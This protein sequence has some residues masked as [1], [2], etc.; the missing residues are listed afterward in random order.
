MAWV[1]ASPPA[2]NLAVFAARRPDPAGSFLAPAVVSGGFTP[3]AFPHAAVTSAGD[4]LLVWQQDVGSESRVWLAEYPSD[5]VAWSAPLAF[6]PSGG[7]GAAPKVVACGD[8]VTVVWIAGSVVQARRRTGSMAWGPVETLDAVGAAVAPLAV[9]TSAACDVT[10]AWRRQLSTAQ[11][12]SAVA[13]AGTCLLY[14][15]DAADE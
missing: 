8:T 3:P 9:A 2:N 13:P 1:T 10:V 14:T 7:S 12:V 4:A 5:A 15:S 6:S 11:M